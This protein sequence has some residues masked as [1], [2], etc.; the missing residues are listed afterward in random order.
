MTKRKK[1]EKM[2]KLSLPRLNESWKATC[3]ASLK[4]LYTDVKSKVKSTN[5]N[6]KTFKNLNSMTLLKAIKKIMYKRSNNNLH[7]KH[8]MAMTRMSFM[9]LYQERF[10]EIQEF[11]GQYGAMHGIWEN[12]SLADASMWPATSATR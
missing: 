11:W 7:I 4:Y 9:S 2:W 8:K 5:E 6:N 10:Q 1:N 12:S 3:A